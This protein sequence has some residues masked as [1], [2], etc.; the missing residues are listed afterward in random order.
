LLQML[1]HLQVLVEQESMM[2]GDFSV[3][4]LGQRCARSS[5]P[6]ACSRRRPIS[7]YSA[8]TAT[9][10]TSLKC[11][12]ANEPAVPVRLGGRGLNGANALPLR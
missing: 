9:P 3:Q 7:A 2:R 1:N 12:T 10:Y 11:S 6:L 5:E 8:P 4:R